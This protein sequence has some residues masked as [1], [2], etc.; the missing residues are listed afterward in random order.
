M[1]LCKLFEVKFWGHFGASSLD[2]KQHKSSPFEPG[3]SSLHYV[4][5]VV[6]RDQFCPKDLL[7]KQ[8][9]SVFGPDHPK[10]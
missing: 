8:I 5:C 1:G 9:E 10:H 6:E 4:H 3:A 2:Y 7:R